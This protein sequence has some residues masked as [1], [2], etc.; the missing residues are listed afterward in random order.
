MDQERVDAGPTCRA[1][2][3]A[4]NRM[5]LVEIDVAHHFEIA[6]EVAIADGGDD[7]VADPAMIN[8]GDLLRGLGRHVVNLDNLEKVKI[9]QALTD[10]R[11]STMQSATRSGVCTAI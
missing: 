3:L 1:K 10:V 6:V 2:R 9:R 8:A 4:Q 11:N 7:D 5:R